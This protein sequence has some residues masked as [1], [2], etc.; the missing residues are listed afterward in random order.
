VRK[1]EEFNLSKTLLSLITNVPAAT[2]W[3]ITDYVKE[4]MDHVSMVMSQVYIGLVIMITVS[5]TVEGTAFDT[6]D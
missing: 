4:R 6:S 1:G 2:F 5:L 3:L